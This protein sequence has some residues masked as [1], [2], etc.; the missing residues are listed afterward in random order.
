MITIQET[1][2][3]IVRQSSYLEDAL[4]N[5]IINSSALARQIKPEIEKKLIKKIELGAVI[6]AIQRLEIKLKKKQTKIKPF[7]NNLIDI[8]VKSNLTTFTFINS[9]ILI[10]RQKELLE[11]ISKERNVFLASTQSL[12]QTT[13]IISGSYKQEV[14]KIFSQE[15]MISNFISL[16]AITLTLSEKTVRTPGV[17]NFI[18]KTLAWYEINIIEI[19]SSFTELTL[20]LESLDI[21]KAFSVLK[22][23]ASQG[24]A[25]RG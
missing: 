24:D 18:L 5:G 22:N 2:E 4:A 13:V 6:M 7:L 20:I 9:P 10:E 11:K 1:T 3:E 8:T 12:F 14:E 16:S 19:V 15:K 25:L 23:L 21:D 17:Y